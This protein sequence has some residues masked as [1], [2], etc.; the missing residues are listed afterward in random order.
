MYDIFSGSVEHAKVQCVIGCIVQGN[1]SCNSSLY[2]S[3]EE[4]G[5]S[6]AIEEI[7]AAVL[8]LSFIGVVAFRST[9]IR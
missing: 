2:W 4:L 5:K 8:F 7:G 3:R 6:K 1:N 9:V